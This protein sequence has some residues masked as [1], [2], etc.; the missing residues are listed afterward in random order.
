VTGE[1]IWP[2]K[3][4]V[5]LRYGDVVAPVLVELD[6]SPMSPEDKAEVEDDRF[7]ITKYYWLAPPTFKIRAKELAPA[8][9]AKAS[10]AY[11]NG[12]CFQPGQHPG[13]GMA[14]QDRRH[15]GERRRLGSTTRP[16]K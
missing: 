4:D 7:A 16:E 13:H 10:D 2:L 11:I 12:Q 15:H 8:K 1:H 3:W 6:G 9:G 5:R 14:T